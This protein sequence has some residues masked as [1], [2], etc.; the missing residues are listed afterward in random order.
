M[1]EAGSGGSGATN[2]DSVIDS[3]MDKITEY[4]LSDDARANFYEFMGKH[5]DKFDFEGDN[6]SE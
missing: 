5:I 1:A 4:A 3:F 6:A 2:D